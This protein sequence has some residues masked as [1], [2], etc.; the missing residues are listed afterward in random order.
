MKSISEKI[1]LGMVIIVGLSTRLALAGDGSETVFEIDAQSS[2]EQVRAF[3]KE[4]KKSNGR[5][6]IRAREVPAQESQI[7]D[8]SSS[9]PVDLIERLRPHRERTARRKQK[10][11]EL[12]ERRSHRVE[13]V[14]E[15]VPVLSSEFTAQADAELEYELRGFSAQE[16]V[17]ALEVDRLIAMDP[18]ES[19]IGGEGQLQE[20]FGVPLAQSTPW[21][22]TKINAPG[23][24]NLTPTK[25]KGAGIKV[26]I[27]DS[28]GTPSHA[29]L[30]YAGGFDAVTNST[31]P[32]AWADSIS[33]CN[34]HGTHVAGTV[35]A[36]DNDVGVVG[37]APE[38]QLYALKV[39]QNLNGSCLAWTSHQIAALQ[40]AVNQGI[41]VVNVSI[42]GSYTGAYDVAISNAA[43]A[44]T[45]TVGAAGNNG[46]VISF[47][48]SSAS[49]FGIG[50][51]TSSDG[52]A[53]FSN[54]GPQLDFMAPG[55]GI[56]STMPSGG[57]GSKSGTSMAAPHFAGVVALVLQAKPNAT[58]SD[59]YTI[60]TSTSLDLGTAGFDQS[61]GH[62]RVNAEA[63]VA[64]ALGGTLPPA[65]DP[66]LANTELELL[67]GFVLSTAERT[68]LDQRGNNNG[69]FDLGDVL[70]RSKR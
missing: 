41:R 28:G 16:G 7:L 36:L 57:Y 2:R 34:G 9:S 69:Q 68:L 19:Q 38:A 3:I 62:G 23:A 22:I 63:A 64:M 18:F 14:F 66:S 50:A 33:V 46:A 44:G 29:D 56:S 53:S 51:T 42:G 25:I 47:P 6:M 8:L 20:D 55:S 35:A 45:F 32:A 17:E 13:S 37:V 59:L 58:F 10:L 61:F 27:I 70:A 67:S 49:A 60:F 21:G 39:F 31:A 11:K 65:P 12:L 52:K 54:T 30:N 4:L 1:V 24:W 43:A 26:G 48:G 15:I 40:W 5:I